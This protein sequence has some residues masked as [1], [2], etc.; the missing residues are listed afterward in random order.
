MNAKQLKQLAQV[1][2]MKRM[3]KSKS[4]ELGLGYVCEL[5]LNDFTPAFIQVEGDK[6]FVYPAGFEITIENHSTSHWTLRTKDMRWIREG[7]LL[8]GKGL[9]TAQVYRRMAN[10]LQAHADEIFKRNCDSI[11]Y[12]DVLALRASKGGAQ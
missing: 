10:E 7:C 12:E 6:S 11:T 8:D 4:R 9:S 1:F 3:L 5:K 2:K